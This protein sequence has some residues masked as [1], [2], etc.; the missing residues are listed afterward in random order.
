LA[1]QLSKQFKLVRIDLYN[2]NN[3]IYVGEITF[4]PYAGIY[5]GEDQK[6]ISELIDLDNKTFLESVI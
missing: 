2:S 4:W 5:K 3:K 6:K 1:S